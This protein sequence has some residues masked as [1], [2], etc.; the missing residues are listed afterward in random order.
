M[1]RSHRLGGDHG[2][3]GRVYP[4]GKPQERALEAV[5]AGEVADA[6]DEGAEKFFFWMLDT[7]SWKLE[8]GSWLLDTRCLIR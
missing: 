2:Y 8:A 4:A 1:L 7:G 6:K 5:F 3:D